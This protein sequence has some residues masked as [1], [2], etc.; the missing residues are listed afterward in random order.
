MKKQTPKASVVDMRE[1]PRVDR[2]KDLEDSMRRLFGCGLTDATEKQV[3]RALCYMLREI[4]TEKNGAFN[5]RVSRN[6]Q[7]EVYYMSMEFLVGT[8]LRNNLF[9]LGMEQESGRA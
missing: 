9:N 4:L 6:E 7:K 5:D 3:Y 2:M 1:E 8:S